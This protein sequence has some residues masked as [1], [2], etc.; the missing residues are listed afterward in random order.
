[1]RTWGRINQV[2]GKG[3]TWVEVSTAAN[4]DNS[5]VYFTTL[6]QV[7]KLNLGESPFFG[8]YGIP[9]LQ[10]V[11]SQIQPDYYVSQVQQQFA[12]FFAALIVSK[13]PQ[14]PNQ[15]NPVYTINATTF[16]G[17]TLIAPVPT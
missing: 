2:N 16:T 12:P 14:Q 15:P 9:A 5:A 6:A 4:G 8:N 17:A 10:S 3:G 13:A 7:L 1:M 11:I